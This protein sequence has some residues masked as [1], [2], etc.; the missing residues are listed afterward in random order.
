[1][2]GKYKR[3][4]NGNTWV[5]GSHTQSLFKNKEIEMYDQQI[6][7]DVLLWIKIQL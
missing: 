1:M 4:E 2:E 5:P 7:Y 6:N 3:P